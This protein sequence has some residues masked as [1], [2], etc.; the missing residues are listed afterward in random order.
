M[1]LRRLNSPS[2][3][4]Q[5][6]FCWGRWLWMDVRWAVMKHSR[7]PTCLPAK[8]TAKN[9][10]NRIKISNFTLDWTVKSDSWM[11]L[12]F[13]WPGNVVNHAKISLK[14]IKFSNGFWNSFQGQSTLEWIHDKKNCQQLVQSY[15]HSSTSWKMLKEH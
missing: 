12:I 8:Q 1:W 11:K 14:A 13:F 4:L 3:W 9:S 6:S 10:M 15:R 2:R 5:R 7:C